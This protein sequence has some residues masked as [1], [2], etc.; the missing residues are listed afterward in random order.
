MDGDRGGKLIAQNV[1][2]NARVDYIAVAP[3][4]K[5]VEELT[6]KEILMNLRKKVPLEEFL[7]RNKMKKGASSIEDSES[8]EEEFQFDEEKR[9]ELKNLGSQIEGTDKAVLLDSSLKEM[10]R[11]SAR[12][13][14]GSLRRGEKTPSVILIDGTVTSS[15]IRAA[16]EANVKVIVAKNFAATSEKIKLLSL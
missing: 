12:A 9:E 7:Y 5:E 16:E 6:G 1:V 10:K 15:L 4:G 13:I 8:V 3:D 11:V 14:S 2:D